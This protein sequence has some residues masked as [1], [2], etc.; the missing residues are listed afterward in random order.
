MPRPNVSEAITR[1]EEKARTLGRRGCFELPAVMGLV[2]ERSLFYNKNPT[3]AMLPRS[4]SPCGLNYKFLFLKSMK[5]VSIMDN[6][7]RPRKPRVDTTR[8]EPRTMTVKAHI[9]TQ[10]PQVS[11]K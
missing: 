4:T 7:P 9:E 3:P 8:H 5:T 6:I 1:P 11:C 2:K 10:D